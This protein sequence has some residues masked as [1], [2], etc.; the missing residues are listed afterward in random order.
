MN[1]PP[2]TI[3]FYPLLEDAHY[4]GNIVKDLFGEACNPMNESILYIHI[5]FCKSH[6]TF[7][8]FNTKV[9]L[10][11]EEVSTYI[12]LLIKEI[13]MLSPMTGDIKFSSV[14][15]GGGSPSVLSAK[16]FERLHSSIVENFDIKNAEISFEGELSTINNYDLLTT[17]I[18]YNVSRISVGVQT[19]D[20]NIRQQFNLQYTSKEALKMLDQLLNYDIKEIN[21]D[22]MYGLPHHNI[23]HLKKDIQNIANIGIS[24]VDYYRLHPYSLPKSQRGEW[25]QEANRLKGDFVLEI[26]E[27]MKQEGFVN[28]CDQVYSK[29]GLS[30]YSKLLWG[31]TAHNQ[32]SYMIGIG[33]SARGYLNGRSYMN[34]QSIK[35][36][37]EKIKTGNLP[38][39][40]VSEVLSVEERRFVFSPKYFRIGSADEYNISNYSEII[41]KWISRGYIFKI[42]DSYILN[43]NGK[44]H[45]DDMIIDAMSSRQY[46]LATGIDKAISNVEGH[47]TGR[48]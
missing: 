25:I 22:M 4:S 48:F 23:S 13:S 7:C 30:N 29:V 47:R 31:N 46:K 27:H 6:C 42:R 19:F 33:A 26:I 1:E 2:V 11:Q 14:Y 37:D 38:V 43:N 5:P 21:A 28:E 35:E 39:D 41:E 32:A 44:I 10:Q 34:A 24:S 8:P 40:K 17:L 20:D 36:Y 12:D 9:L 45:I 3:Y 15:Y 18:S 16:D